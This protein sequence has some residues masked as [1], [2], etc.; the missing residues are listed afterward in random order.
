MSDNDAKNIEHRKLLG[1]IEVSISSMI[2]AHPKTYSSYSMTSMDRLNYL[3]Q[4]IYTLA[5]V[6]HDYNEFKKFKDLRTGQKR[7]KV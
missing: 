7:Q 5:C 2:F 3:M 4:L 1:I 6:F